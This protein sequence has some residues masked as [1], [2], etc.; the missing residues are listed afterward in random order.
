[1][2]KACEV[3]GG[4][5]SLRVFDAKGLGEGSPAFGL[6][7]CPDCGFGRTEPEVPDADIGK[8]YPPEYYG[9][10]NIRF[11]L[12]FEMLIRL[13]RRRRAWTMARQVPPG[14]ALD[15]GCG[16]GF[17]LHFLRKRGFEPH[18]VELTENGAWHARHFLNIDMRVG[19]FLDVPYPDGSFQA[20]VFWHS[21][22]HMRR[23]LDALR[24]ASGILR[25]GGLVVVA[26]PNSDSLQARLF[27]ASWF[28][29]DIPRHYVHFGARSLRAALE[30]AGFRVVKTDHFCLEQN[31]Y[32]WMQSL[33]NALGFKFNL[34]YSMLKNRTAR[35]IP[36][37]E[38][39]V[40]V[41]LCLALVPVVL[42]LSL[43]LTVAEA[44]LR[45]GG[46][47]EMYAIKEGG[48]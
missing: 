2:T 46:T 7:R 31:P 35:T 42:P 9:K 16:R 30:S 27:G 39:P 23:P 20:V 28:H 14:P 34:L 12:P 21:L 3:C 38:H 26:V 18:G 4:S 13:L 43:A 45:R 36:I 24:R 10:D 17:I 48:R 47:M 15:V 41:A 11:N 29:L 6:R 19:N 44:A 1:M 5:S 22:E 32:G 33:Y 40:Q 8:W 25:P 37:R